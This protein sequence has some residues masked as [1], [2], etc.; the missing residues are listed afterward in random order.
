MRWLSLL[1]VPLLI[2]SFLRADEKDEEVVKQKAKALE[3]LKKCDVAKPALIETQDLIV[4]GPLPEDKLKT[5]GAT[6]QKQYAAALKSLKFEA[7]DPPFKGKLII[8]FFPERKPYSFF[9]SEV[10]GER[11]E[12]H[13]RS[14]ADGRGEPAYVAV[15][16]PPAEKAT[17]LEAEAGLQSAVALFQAK[18]GPARLPAGMTAG[19]ARAMI[20]RQ[21]PTAAAKDRGT[22]RQV[23]AKYKAGDVWSPPENVDVR[24]KQLITA[25]FTEYLVFGPESAKLGKFLA[26]FRTAEGDP[27]PSVTDALAGAGIAVDKLD[28]A[29]KRWVATGK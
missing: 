27:M 21:N 24:E 15:S 10:I 7:S 19:F 8:Y 26:A 4:C 11:L 3:I 1:T 18:A 16:V 5:M 20:M 28:A 29:W 9:V 17:D 6:V 23:L 2:V 13:D 12:K 14:H 22:I 25:S